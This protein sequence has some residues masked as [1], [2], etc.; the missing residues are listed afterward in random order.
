MLSC[1][2]EIFLFKR[3]RREREGDRGREGEYMNPALLKQNQS[4]CPLTAKRLPSGSRSIMLER[5]HLLE[6]QHQSPQ[7]HDWT[8]AA[9]SLGRLSLALLY[10]LF[11]LEYFNFLAFSLRETL[12]NCNHLII[13]NQYSLAMLIAEAIKKKKLRKRSNL[14]G[15]YN[16]LRGIRLVVVIH[17]WL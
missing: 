8:L 6:G 1:V 5:Q 15:A 17:Q 3:N 7:E 16:L 14:L 9:T 11:T 12:N 2:V 13:F 4:V 10:G